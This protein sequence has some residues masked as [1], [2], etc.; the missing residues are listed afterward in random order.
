MANSL[1]HANDRAFE[2]AFL[3]LLP[4]HGC[5]SCEVT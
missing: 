4:A 2:S 3:V 5:Y 1:G